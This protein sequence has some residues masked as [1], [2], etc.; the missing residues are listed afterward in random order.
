MIKLFPSKLFSIAAAS[1]VV[2]TTAAS[3]AAER[4][5]VLFIATDDLNMSV[6]CFGDTPVKTPNI[7]RLAA[8]GVRFDRAYCQFPLCNP[9]R[10]SLMTGR[11][12]DSTKVY[13]NATRFRQA[14]GDV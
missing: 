10:S 5:N 8:R 13:D 1:F 3:L 12:P 7:D 11:R 2:I 6:G 9:S 4:P 14:L